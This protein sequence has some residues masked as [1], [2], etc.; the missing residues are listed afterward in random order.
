[1]WNGMHQNV[2]VPSPQRKTRPAPAQQR[3]GELPSSCLARTN[4]P[5]ARQYHATPVPR[6]FQTSTRVSTVESSCLNEDPTD[7]PENL[8][9]VRKH[10]VSPAWQDIP[11]IL[12][13]R[14]SIQDG[15][16]PQR[17][18]SRHKHASPKKQIAH[19]VALAIVSIS[20]H[21]T[22]STHR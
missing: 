13:I 21:P 5:I 20:F 9:P 19:H 22:A 6:C 15:C 8:D 14:T 4:R 11:L 18:Q 16:N 3:T 7:K 17:Y 2:L 1:M 12:W 10:Y